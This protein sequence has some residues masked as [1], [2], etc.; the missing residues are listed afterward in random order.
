[1]AAFTT[2]QFEKDYDVY[3][4]RQLV[5]DV[6]RQFERIAQGEGAAAGG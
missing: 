6:T 2:V 5:E 3:K 4:Q 1:M